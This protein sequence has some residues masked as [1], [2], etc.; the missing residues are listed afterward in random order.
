M[1]KDKLGEKKT[2]IAQPVD[3]DVSFSKNN[4][5]IVQGN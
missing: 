5:A 3:M 4:N 2:E 1:T